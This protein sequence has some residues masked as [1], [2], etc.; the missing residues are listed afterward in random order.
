M[1]PEL[2]QCHGSA[3]NLVLH[4]WGKETNSKLKSLGVSTTFHSLPNLNH[5]LNKT[6]LEKLKSWILTRLPGETDGQS[7]WF[8][9][10]I[11]IVHLP[12]NIFSYL[13][14]TKIKVFETAR[15]PILYKWNCISVYFHST[16][17]SCKSSCSECQLFILLLHRYH[18]GGTLECACPCITDLGD[19]L[20]EA[21]INRAAMRCKHPP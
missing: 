17:L 12:F 3:D 14:L 11:L 15:A 16:R 4:A 5:E 9:T 7:E 6:E 20:C 10:S 21:V 2:F 18:W 19:F 8:L 1:L 13:I